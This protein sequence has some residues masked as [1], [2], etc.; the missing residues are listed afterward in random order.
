[1]IGSIK[2]QYDVYLLLQSL[3]CIV[4]A[5]PRPGKKPS[6]LSFF[7][8]CC[9]TTDYYVEI[10]TYPQVVPARARIAFLPKLARYKSETSSCHPKSRT[11]G[12]R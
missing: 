7:P 2:A 8:Q 5:L 1:M 9:N 10:V 4:V 6:V 3:F 12:Q 11:R